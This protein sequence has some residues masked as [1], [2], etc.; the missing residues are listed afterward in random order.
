M[1]FILSIHPIFTQSLEVFINKIIIEQNPDNV[2][3]LEILKSHLAIYEGQVFNTF[4]ELHSALQEQ[5]QLLQNTR[6]FDNLEITATTADY[7][8]T[9]Y[10]VIIEF[11][12]GLTFFAIPYPIPDTSIG[13]NGWSFGLKTSYDNSFGTM[14][15][16]TLDASMD[17]AFGE[18]ETLKGWEINTDLSNIMV[19]DSTLS[20]EYIQTYK[21]TEVTDPSV[22]A[23]QQLIQHYS[24]HGSFLNLAL[25]FELDSLWSYTFNPELGFRYNYD[26]HSE[27]EG[28]I[29]QKNSNV[30]ED[31]V[32]IIISNSISNEKVDWIGPLRDGWSFDITNNLCLL[33]SFFNKTQ[34][35]SL[36]LATD[37][38]LSGKWYKKIGEYLNYYTKLNAMA[39]FDNYY[40]ELGSRLRGIKNSSMY[41]DLG[42]F[43]QNTMGIE[44]FG[45][46]LFH[47]QLHPFVDTGIALYTKEIKPATDLFRI[48]F[49]IEGILMIGSVDISG[50]LGYDPVSDFVD[51][52]LSTDLSY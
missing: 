15:D 27:F 39:V 40:T 2:T 17:F 32:S 44:L 42:I 14:T 36:R 38:E 4:Q 8:I 45:N 50:I 51:L 22:P 3:Q 7:A 49:G 24:N 48:G 19:G 30:V 1:L 33:D 6:Y 31:R 43:W 9:G 16:F 28:Q 35:K 18:E 34:S 25:T 20:F 23:E 52:S 13:K 46:E 47:A 12:D 29:T 5:E 26:Y 11:E 21:D 10:D 37:F 41:G